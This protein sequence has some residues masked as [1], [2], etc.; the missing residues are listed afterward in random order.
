[1]TKRCLRFPSKIRVV[2][3]DGCKE[4]TGRVK[5]VVVGGIGGHRH[6]VPSTRE[7]EGRVGGRKTGIGCDRGL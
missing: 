3:A 1:M 2:Y 7:E 6:H 4:Q 5:D